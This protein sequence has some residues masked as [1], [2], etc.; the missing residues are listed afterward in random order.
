MKT[1]PLI[2]SISLELPPLSRMAVDELYHFL[3]YLQFKHDVDLE[4]VLEDLEDEMDGFDGELAREETG[5]I[6]LALFKQELANALKGKTWSNFQLSD[7]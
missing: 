2:S 3:Q 6:S 4:S 7:T 5:E 1:L